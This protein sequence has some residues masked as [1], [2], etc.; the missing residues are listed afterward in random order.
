[1]YIF[2]HKQQSTRALRSDRKISWKVKLQ[3]DNIVHTY[4]QTNLLSFKR[5][6]RYIQRYYYIL[7]KGVSY[8]LLDRV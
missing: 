6:I 3:I 4:M 5:Y 8:P 1:M 7:L 2:I